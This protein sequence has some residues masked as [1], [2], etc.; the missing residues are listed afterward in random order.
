MSSKKKAARKV[1]AAYV[2]DSRRSVV[3]SIPIGRPGILAHLVSD[4]LDAAEDWKHLAAR[5]MVL[6][7]EL[8]GEALAVVEAPTDDQP[9]VS[10][11]DDRSTQ[12]RPDGIGFPSR[13]SNG[14]D[15]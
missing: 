14:D 12:G 9:N 15:Q 13:G 10:L 8:A 4:I 5:A 3:G 6:G 2:G 1:S 11:V 7:P